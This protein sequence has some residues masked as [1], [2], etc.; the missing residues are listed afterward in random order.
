M[1]NAIYTA[2]GCVRCK[3]TKSFLA[4]N[5]I[6]FEEFDFKGEGQ[7]AF[8]QFYR[9]NR[10]DIFR[11]QDGVEFPVFSDGNQ[12]RQGVSVIIGYL[13][14]GNKLDGF[15]RRSL[16]HGEWIDGFDVSGGDPKEVGDLV[17]VLGYLKDKRLK[18][19]LTGNGV[20]AEVLERLLAAGLGDRLIME[21]KGPE[22]LLHALYGSGATAAEISK[23]LSLAA[24]FPEYSLVTTIAPVK[25]E[26]GEITYL[27]PEEVG[28]TANFIEQATG[29]KKNPYLLRAFRP[30]EID[31]QDLKGVEPLPQSAMF[32]YRSA[33]RRFQVLTEVEK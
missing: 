11:D 22:S 32:K 7:D 3:I 24:K 26:G 17:E 28:D 6:E 25:R 9:A 18:I 16:L 31:D 30:D 33:A 5:N 19:Q 14:S 29:S 8:G 2:T 21:V 23:S 10:K 20:N 4:E 12:I 15:I 1:S 27:T 13:V